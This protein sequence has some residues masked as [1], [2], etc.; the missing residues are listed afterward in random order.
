[1][2]RLSGKQEEYEQIGNRDGTV[3]EVWCKRE[4]QRAHGERQSRGARVCTKSMGWPQW[5]QSILGGEDVSVVSGWV[6][7]EEVE[8][9]KERR[10]CW[11]VMSRARRVAPKKPS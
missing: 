8:V 3:E 10:C 11:M 7:A 1:M 9:V 6:C 2:I 5:G 4:R